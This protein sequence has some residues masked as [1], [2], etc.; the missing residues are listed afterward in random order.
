MTQT[1]KL[2]NGYEIPQIGFGVFMITDPD[3]CERAVLD[4]L[5]AGYRLIDTANAYMNERAVGR[6]LKKSGLEREEIFLTTKIMPQDFGYTRTRTAI[7]KTLARLDTP[8]I[9]LLLLHIR[10][11]DYMGAWRALEEAVDEGKV[12]SIGISN[13]NEARIRNILDNGRIVP[14]VD[15]IECHPYFQERTLRRL[16]DRHDIRVESF[17]PIGHGDRN[18]L[19]E[20]VFA[21][22]GEKYGKSPAQVILKWHIQ[23]GFVPLPKST[24]PQHIRDN[25]DLDFTLSEEDMNAIRAIDKDTSYFDTPEEEQERMFLSQ[26][27]DFDDQK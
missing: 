13:F 6:A 23:E 5:A 17:Y 24:N 3:E 11:G 25:I 2:N 4:A 16:L 21:R 19:S 26:H 1:F 22:L 20:P 7:D 14:Q 18:L 27:I 8:Y 15:Q 12:R 10:F 9:D